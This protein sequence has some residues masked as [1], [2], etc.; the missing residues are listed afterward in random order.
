MSRT[1]KEKQQKSYCLHKM[2]DFRCLFSLLSLLPLMDKFF[3]QPLLY[4]GVQHHPGQENLDGQH[5]GVFHC[6]GGHVVEVAL[7][8]EHRLPDA[9]QQHIAAVVDDEPCQ[10]RWQN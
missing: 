6:A 1:H 3:V 5:D 4:G 8:V 9:A 10:L 7:A 2:Y